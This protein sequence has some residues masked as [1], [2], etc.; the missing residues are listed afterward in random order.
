[1]R[2][3]EASGRSC[4]VRSGQRWL[5]PGRDYDCA[6]WR[7]AQGLL[8]VFAQ[9]VDAEIAVRLEPALVHLDREARIGCRR[10]APSGTMRTTWLVPFNR[11]V[12]AKAGAGKPEASGP[13]CH[14]EADSDGPSPAMTAT[15]PNA[16]AARKRNEDRR[17]TYSDARLYL[18]YYLVNRRKLL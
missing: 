4:H 1:M 3:A 18:G 8:L 16:I 2:R 14:D 11:L 9:V 7:H 12:P 10:F 15:A 6:E 13:S 17:L 5:E